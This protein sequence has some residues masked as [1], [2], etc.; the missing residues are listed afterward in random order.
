MSGTLARDQDGK[1]WPYD[2]KYL[3]IVEE[4]QEQLTESWP[5]AISRAKFLDTLLLVAENPDEQT[6]AMIHGVL[7]WG[8]IKDIEQARETFWKKMNGLIVPRPG[9]QGV[10]P[11]LLNE[12]NR[13]A[14][15]YADPYDVD[16]DPVYRANA[17]WEPLQLTIAQEQL[18]EKMIWPDRS[19]SS[20][21]P[22]KVED[23]NENG[24]EEYDGWEEFS[25]EDLVDSSADG[26]ENEGG[27]W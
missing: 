19:S 12:G 7:V 9:A 1:P 2:P 27:Q 20:E 24:D 15:I 5:G 13:K 17:A 25:D 6:W 14:L 18:G 8:G 3:K 10:A 11:L 16:H 23:E 21:R 22:V 4:T 26:S